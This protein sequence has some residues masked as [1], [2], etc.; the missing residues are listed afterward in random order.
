MTAMTAGKTTSKYGNVYYKMSAE[1]N[2][3]AQQKHYAENKEQVKAKAVLKSIE[4]GMCPRLTT[5]QKYAD[6]LTEDKI[7]ERFRKFR[8]GC[9]N[10]EELYNRSKKLFELVEQMKK[11]N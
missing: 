7:T 9:E 10:Q 8:S 1:K 3:I 11:R 2:R 4:Q 5:L 6:Y